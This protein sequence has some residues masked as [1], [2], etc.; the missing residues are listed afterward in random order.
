[1]RVVSDNYE[2]PSQIIVSGSGFARFTIA[3][4]VT[5]G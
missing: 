3:V 4:N 2:G 1:M 5:T